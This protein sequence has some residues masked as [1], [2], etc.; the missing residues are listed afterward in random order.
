M[1]KHMDI[2]DIE[3]LTV[4]E[5]EELRANGEA[6]LLN[7]KDHNCYLV[8]L[9]GYFGYSVL[10]FKNS[11]HIYYANDYQ[12]HH[13][14]KTKEELR[15]RYIEGLKNKLFTESELM[16]NVQT[17]ANYERMS[18]YVRNY[19]IMQFDHVSIFYIGKPTEEQKK[20]KEEMVFC[21]TCFCYV[22][23]KTVVEKA[24]K[25]IN[26]IEK[27]FS[28][29]KENEEVF[30]EM[31]SYELAN[32]EAGYTGSYTDAL[33]SLGLEFNNLTDRQRSI[34]TEELKLQIQYQRIKL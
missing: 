24:Y 23:D 18:Y 33:E 4:Q 3:A 22:S 8:D 5:M 13:N 2:Y 32:H 6:E 16:E 14:N 7:I 28:E 15:T 29:A 34:V 17:Y 1:K 20:A 31:I 10:V 11:H 12:L 19:W 25:L 21:P 30:R 26:H 9:K 27:S